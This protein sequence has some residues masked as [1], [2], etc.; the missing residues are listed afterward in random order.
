M[1]TGES[2]RALLDAVHPEPDG[3]TILFPIA[4]HDRAIGLLYG[5]GVP[6]GDPGLLED[7]AAAVATT[8]VVMENKLFAKLNVPRK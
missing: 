7:L 3:E 1:P 4:L 8:A 6:P 2:D 5:D